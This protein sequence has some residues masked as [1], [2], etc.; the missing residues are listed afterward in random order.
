MKKYLKGT[1]LK[2]KH[3]HLE[4]EIL[5]VMT[6]HEEKWEC[7]EVPLVD[8]VVNLSFVVAAV[9]EIVA[10]AAAVESGT[11]CSFVCWKVVAAC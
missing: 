8:L 6:S 5:A 10:G 11:Y 3:C 9:D 7:L 2:L 1:H 4:L